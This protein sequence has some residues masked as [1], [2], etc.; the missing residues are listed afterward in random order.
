[1]M[2]SHK[3]QGQGKVKLLTNQIILVR[4]IVLLNGK[5][6][7]FFLTNLLSPGLTLMANINLVTNNM[8]N[9]TYLMA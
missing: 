8:T 2:I 5:I 3:G 7:S 4:D 1:M 6:K 9:R